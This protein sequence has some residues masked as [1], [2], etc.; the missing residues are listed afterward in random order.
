MINM[1]DLIKQQTNTIRKKSGMKI[2]EAFE[3]E[4]VQHLEAEIFDAIIAFK[5]TFEKSEW[6]KDR[7]INSL[8]KQMFKLESTLGDVVGNLE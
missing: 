8:I 4:D 1:K 3:I 7:K 5:K 2:N 6:K